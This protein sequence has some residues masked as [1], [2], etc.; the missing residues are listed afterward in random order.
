[1]LDVLPAEGVVF[2]NHLQQIK[3]GKRIFRVA[4]LVVEEADIDV[5]GAME[6]V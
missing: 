1:M 5:L 4:V 2:L 3:M 6:L